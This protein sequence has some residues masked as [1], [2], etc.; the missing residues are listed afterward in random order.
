MTRFDMPG[1]LL[2][3]LIGWPCAAAVVCLI[4]MGVW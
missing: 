3:D 1:E 4:F 2:G